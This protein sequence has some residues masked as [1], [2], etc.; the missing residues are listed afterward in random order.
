VLQQGREKGSGVAVITDEFMRE[1]RGKEVHA[2]HGSF[3][4]S[5]P[6]RQGGGR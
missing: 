4:D 5:L 2:V 6:P 3:G 1:M